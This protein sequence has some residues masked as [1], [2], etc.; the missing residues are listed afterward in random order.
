MEE[1]ERFFEKFQ[2]KHDYTAQLED[3]GDSVASKLAKAEWVEKTESTD[4]QNVFS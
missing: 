4:I 1:I 3:G 2:I